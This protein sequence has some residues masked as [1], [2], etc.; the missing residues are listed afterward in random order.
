MVMM[1]DLYL[2]Q[3]NVRDFKR[4]RLVELDLNGE[5]AVV[6]GGNGQGKS[7][8]IDGFW[9]VLQGAK[10]EPEVPIRQGADQS[11][12][13]MWLGH[14]GVDG[15][16]PTV[17]LK[18]RLVIGVAGSQ[19]QVT[20]AEGLLHKKPQS[21][22]DTLYTLVG[23]DPMRFLKMDAKEQTA[24]LRKVCGCNT[25]DV[26]S[27]IE[28]A[29]DVRRNA[30]READRTENLALGLG[31]PEE[32]PPSIDLESV[33]AELEAVDELN[34]KIAL[35]HENRAQLERALEDEKRAH[36]RLSE[37]LRTSVEAIR[38]RVEEHKAELEAMRA[39]LTVVEA[40]LEEHRAKGVSLRTTIDSLDDIAPPSDRGPLLERIKA[41]NAAAAKV[42]QVEAANA[43]RSKAQEARVKAALASQN[44]EQALKD[45]RTQRE[46]M[47][48]SAK[49]PVD[50]LGIDEQGRVTFGGVPFSQCSSA[51]R[52]RVSCALSMESA[53]R[54]KV[55]TIRDGNDLDDA[56]LVALTRYAAE[57]RFQL[58]I[59]RISGG[60]ASLDEIVIEDGQLLGGA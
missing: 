26:D 5:S 1:D 44:A 30:K 28:T 39:N 22:L 29:M 50:G 54:L 14:P 15:A 11:V 38:K 52:I 24:M 17:L 20:N 46:A 60:G 35:A 25:T 47:L 9:R 56:S 36:F 58:L 37:T 18:A 21:V 12:L 27:Q 59:E 23:F 13:E 33:M 34:R 51:E 40:G 16:P 53:G 43:N 2:L 55:M 4:I 6:A 19:I 41:S 48:A 42:A 3:L 57:H 49:F 31:A 45:L 7:S 10:V 8:L 32:L